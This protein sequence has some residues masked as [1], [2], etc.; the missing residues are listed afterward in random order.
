MWS[1]RHLARAAFGVMAVS[2]RRTNGPHLRTSG[3]APPGRNTGCPAPRRPAHPGGR[4]VLVRLSYVRSNRA[5]GP[6][7]PERLPP[8]H[9]SGRAPT[10]GPR[11]GRRISALAR[12]GRVRHGVRSEAGPLVP[13]TGWRRGTVPACVRSGDGGAPSTE[14]VRGQLAEARAGCPGSGHRSRS[15]DAVLPQPVRHGVRRG[16]T[17]A[18]SG[19]RSGRGTPVPSRSG[20]FRAC[21]AA[22]RPASPSPGL[23]PRPSY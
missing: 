13:G 19:R 11:T 23:A 20:D 18:G 6:T 15:P 21:D 16:E 17:E 10:R 7:P 3:A 14:S 8:A 12:G 9:R 22:G 2:E 1:A 5:C 4:A